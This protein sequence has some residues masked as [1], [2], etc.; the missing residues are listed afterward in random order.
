MTNRPT[1]RSLG[2]SAGLNNWGK[3]SRRHCKTAA[4]REAWDQG[5]KE[6]R[7]ARKTPVKPHERG[8]R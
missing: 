6:G 2:L 8:R 4:D 7:E 5:Y 3:G 1:P